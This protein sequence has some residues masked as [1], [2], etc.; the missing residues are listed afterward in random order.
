M[1]DK[2][3]GKVA[4]ILIRLYQLT[5]SPWLGRSCRF[6]PTCSK[7]AAD[8]YNQHSSLKATGLV[9]RRL[10]RCHPLGGHG[11]DPVPVPSKRLVHE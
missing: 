2:M 6:T 10:C 1:L 11:Y 8:A 7:Y 4:L 5:L 3:F 9:I